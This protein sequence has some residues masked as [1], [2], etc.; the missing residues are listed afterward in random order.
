MSGEVNQA[1]QFNIST[2]S[3]NSI[4][5]DTS[6]IKIIELFHKI[7]KLLSMTFDSIT[8][9]TSL[10]DRLNKLIT[11]VG[12]MQPY[13]NHAQLGYYIALHFFYHALQ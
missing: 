3:V 2:N 5:N 7:T 9:H 1:D 11:Q 6:F 4:N 8:S 12:A 13:L 10:I